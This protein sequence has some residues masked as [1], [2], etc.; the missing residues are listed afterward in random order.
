MPINLEQFGIY[1]PL[2][3]YFRYHPPQTPERIQ[4]HERVNKAS[5]D[6]A[7][8]RLNNLEELDPTAAQKDVATFI[9]VVDEL[10]TDRYLKAQ[11]NREYEKLVD[12]IAEKN[13]RLILFTIQI[14]RMLANQ[15]ITIQELETQIKTP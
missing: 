15:A 9:A 10:V 8:S 13:G 2:E 1:G 4:A 14:I 6:V 5:F 3:E 7:N 11:I 12:H